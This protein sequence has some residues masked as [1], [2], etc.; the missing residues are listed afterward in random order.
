[1][2]KTKG[3]HKFSFES[4][5]ILGYIPQPRGKDAALLGRVQTKPGGETRRFTEA[6]MCREEWWIKSTASSVLAA[7]LEQSYPGQNQRLG[8]KTYETLV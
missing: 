8:G 2:I 3:L 1:M 7:V 5:K 6:K 4:S